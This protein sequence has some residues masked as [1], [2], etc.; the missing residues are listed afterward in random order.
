MYFHQPWAWTSSNSMNL[1]RIQMLNHPLLADGNY[2]C[3]SQASSHKHGVTACQ[4]SASPHRRGSM[5]EDHSG[6][7][8]YRF[9]ECYEWDFSYGANTRAH[10][11]C[12]VCLGTHAHNVYACNAS[13]T[14]DGQHA[15]DRKSTRLN[16]SHLRTSRM[17]SSA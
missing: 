15:T 5:L 8:H 11:V 10:S 16:S 17:P 14:W 1:I 12:A 9:N 13:R 4:H 7:H 2:C 6:P 3:N